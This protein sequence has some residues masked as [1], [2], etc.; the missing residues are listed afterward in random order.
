[1]TSSTT[2]QETIQEAE[3]TAVKRWKLETLTGLLGF[4]ALQNHQR[5]TELNTAAENSH[6]RRSVWGSKEES[7]EGADDMGS[8]GNIVLGDVQ[9][10][11]PIVIAGQQSGGSDLVKGLAIAALGAAIPGA[12]LAGYFIS[13]AMD[14]TPAPVVL[15]IDQND[16]SVGLGKIEDYIKANNSVSAD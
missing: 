16:F 4:K 12:G 14:K 15:P 9:H 10:P 3:Q 8:G 1:M 2:Q 6:V 11:T 5:E 13:N 7:T